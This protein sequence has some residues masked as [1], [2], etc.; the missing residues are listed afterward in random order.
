MK[1][2]GLKELKNTM[3]ITD[4][5]LSSTDFNNLQTN[6]MGDYFPWFYNDHKVYKGDNKFQFTHRLYDEENIRSEH[7]YLILPLLKKLNIERLLRVKANLVTRTSK[8]EVF[9]FHIDE[10]TNNPALRTAIFYC[11]TNNG[12]TLFKKSKKKVKS[13]ANRLVV[14]PGQ[15]LHT[16]STCTDHNAR[17]VI[18]FNFYPV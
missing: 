3:Q 15:L 10:E 11:N 18:N 9:K 8:L 6:I 17:V 13:Q 14:F 1:T 12:Y 5:F 16:G 2:N 4:K 7:Y